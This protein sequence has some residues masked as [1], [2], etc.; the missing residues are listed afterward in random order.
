VRGSHLEDLTIRFTGGLGCLMSAW[1]ITDKRQISSSYSET[2][3]HRHRSSSTIL[4]SPLFGR[5]RDASPSRAIAQTPQ[6]KIWYGWPT[7]RS[8]HSH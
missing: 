2:K 5:Y 1:A 3:H 6:E 4:S 8:D 7:L